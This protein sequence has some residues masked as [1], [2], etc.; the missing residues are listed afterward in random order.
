MAR[1]RDRGI[2]NSGGFT[3][4]ELLTVIVLFAVL[5]AYAAPQWGSVVHRSRAE[6]AANELLGALQFAKSEAVKRN[7]RVAITAVDTNWSKGWMIQVDAN[8][9]GAFDTPALRES[10]ALPTSV[11]VTAKEDRDE[12]AQAVA[13][14]VFVG[15]GT[16]TFD[17]GSS[18]RFSVTAPLAGET[19]NLSVSGS[20]AIRSL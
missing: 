8:R 12:P 9:D 14:V 5:I 6:S 20:G 18:A 7:R 3:L 16:A 13:Q 11:V 1:F 4:I 19:R 17:Q 2:K 15:L 10:G